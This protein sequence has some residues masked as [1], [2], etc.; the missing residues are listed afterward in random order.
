MCFSSNLIHSKNGF[1]HQVKTVDAKKNYSNRAYQLPISAQFRVLLRTL[2]D[3][4]TS[5]L[6]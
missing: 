3:S 6:N 1:D 5:L 4:D 2:P